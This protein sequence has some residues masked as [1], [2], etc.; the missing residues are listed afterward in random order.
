MPRLPNRDKL[1]AAWKLTR[2]DKRMDVHETRYRPR[3]PLQ[4]PLSDTEWRNVKRKLHERL[5]KHHTKFA[6]IR[7]MLLTE[8]GIYQVTF[9][10]EPTTGY[11]IDYVN[12]K[13]VPRNKANVFTEEEL[14]RVLQQTLGDLEKMSSEEEMEVFIVAFDIVAHNGFWEKVKKYDRSN[15]TQKP[16]RRGYVR[17]FRV[18]L[19]KGPGR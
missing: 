7:L 11:R 14:F 1:T 3:N 12:T 10:I 5:R 18:R 4:V 13:L 6:Y 15:Y 17:T 19:P 8:E 16:E 9:E 2:S